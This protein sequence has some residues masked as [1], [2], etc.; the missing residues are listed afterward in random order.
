MLL[1]QLFE[2]LYEEKGK[3]CYL[4]LFSEWLYLVNHST[5]YKNVVEYKPLTTHLSIYL[6]IFVELAFTTL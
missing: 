3:K 2:S 1:K 5:L 4:L 6:F